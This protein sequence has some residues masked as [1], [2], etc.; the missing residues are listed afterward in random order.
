MLVSVQTERFI[1]NSAVT[2]LH[3]ALLSLLQTSAMDMSTS[4][5]KTSGKKRGGEGERGEGEERAGTYV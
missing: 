5:Q 4:T 3:P 2:P 1:I